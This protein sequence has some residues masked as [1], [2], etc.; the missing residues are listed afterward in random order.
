MS[1]LFAVALAQAEPV[2][3]IVV[4][5]EA[6]REQGYALQLDGWMVE[7]ALPIDVVEGETVHLVDAE[8]RKELLDVAAGEAW[9][10]S[11]DAGDAWMSVLGED[12]RTDLVAI[13][14]DPESVVDLAT[15]LGV[16][17]FRE[18]Q[19]YYLK[20]DDVLFAVPW[21]K[22]R[23]ASTIREVGLVGTD[24]VL[25]NETRASPPLRPTGAH[26]LPRFVPPRPP[27]RTA[28]TGPPIIP[29]PLAEVA[30]LAA[31]DGRP[32]AEAPPRH[33]DLPQAAPT[34]RLDAEPN[35]SLDPEAYAGQ[36]RCRNELMWL[37][38]AGVF[39]FRGTTGTW[40]VSAPGVVRMYD[41]EGKLLARAAVEPE[42]GF[43]REAW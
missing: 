32:S 12:V 35:V 38:P 8:G 3:A 20:G 15:D 17:V 9:E 21:T 29:R 27:A 7:D 5:D 28:R 43:C 18:G 6:A 19:R 30:P 25:E 42:R 10:V 16:D 34:V 23:L 13:V 11:G 22:A 33:Q 36:Y 41:H 39:S 37:H 26:D 1:L 2:V 40:L 4:V 14:G 31:R 24:E